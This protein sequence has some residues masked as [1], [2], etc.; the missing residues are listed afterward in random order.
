M[1]KLLVPRSLG[2]CEEHVPVFAKYPDHARRNPNFKLLELQTLY[3]FKTLFANE[4][5]CTSSAPS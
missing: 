1:T 5:I 2:T 3:F 4:V